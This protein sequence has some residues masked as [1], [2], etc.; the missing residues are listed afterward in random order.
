[1]IE[2]K[3]L[4]YGISSTEFLQKVKSVWEIHYFSTPASRRIAGFIWDYFLAQ[5]K[6]PKKEIETIVLS[7][8]KSIAK[9]IF[10]DLQ[11]IIDGISTDYTEEEFNLDYAVETAKRFFNE[12]KLVLFKENLTLLLDTGN[13]EEANKAVR[14]YTTLD[15]QNIEI[16][17]HILSIQ[18]IR[19]LNR[20]PPIT[21][22]KPWLKAG[23]I[24]I[25]Y[26][27]YGC[28]KSLFTIAVSY[29]LGLENYIDIDE[30][31]EFQVKTPTGV[32]YVDGEL[33]M[34]EMEERVSQF[35]W[36]GYQNRDRRMQILSVP[37]YQLATEDSFY[38][39]NRLNQLKIINW[40]RENENYKVLVLDSASTLFGLIQENDNSE[41][42]NKINPFLR[43]LRALGVACILLHHSGKNNKKGLR[44]ASAMG[45]MAH[46]I[47]RLEMHS[48]K[49]IDD[50]EAWFTLSK[51]KQRSAGVQFR[52]FSL[53]F[54]RSIDDKE[55][56]WEETSNG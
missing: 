42:N 56:H 52:K 28:G 23:Q 17:N 12:R 51:D 50:G 30:M 34:L 5:S 2:R 18:Q 20:T 4:Y 11:E 26:G 37:E 15:I 45:A 43:D 16:K 19:R 9:D 24:T 46:N 6:A 48:G 44:G 25:I 54:T 21:F 49:N 40:L 31:G 7:K 33:G 27:D 3:I 10:E 41:W 32:L 53:R 38:L 8:Q 14:D 55:T 13:I 35:E 22:L 39:S 36:L 47:F 1:M 29:M